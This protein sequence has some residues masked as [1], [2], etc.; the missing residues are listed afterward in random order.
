MKRKHFLAGVALLALTFGASLVPAHAQQAGGRT[1]GILTNK[2]DN[3]IEVKADG[4]QTPRRLMPRFVAAPRPMPSGLDRAMLARFQTLVV[5]NRVDLIWTMDDALRVVQIT[6]VTPRGRSG[7]VTG[8]VDE[9]GRGWVDVLP[10]EDGDPLERY[11]PAWSEDDDAP[12]AAVL[13]QLT[14]LKAGDNVTLEW[15]Y[16]GVKRATTVT[17]L[18][19]KQDEQK[20]EQ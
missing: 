19:P 8:T 6:Q 12:D 17:K 5:G 14:A 2:S 1:G 13:K 10:D 20:A 3:W 7:K 18:A 16:D 15:T 4:E 9:A 11:Y